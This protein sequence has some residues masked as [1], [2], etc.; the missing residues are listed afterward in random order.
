MLGA[1]T[2]AACG[3]CPAQLYL[4]FYNLFFTSL[5]PIV[6][7]IFDQ[8][9]PAGVLDAYP[10]LYQLGM[11]GRIYNARNFWMN[12]A[13]ACWESVMIFFVPLL[14]Y[15]TSNVGLWILGTIWNTLIILCVTASLALQTQYWTWINGAVVGLSLLA[16]LLFAIVYNSLLYQPNVYYV[17]EHLLGDSRFYLCLLLAVPL[18]LLPRFLWLVLKQ[19]LLLNP[20]DALRQLVLTGR[21]DRDGNAADAG[22]EPTDVRASAGSILRPSQPSSDEF[23]PPPLQRRAATQ[24]ADAGRGRRDAL[25]ASRV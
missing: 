12:I 2:D 15:A 18:A 8:D 9:L 23:G 19:D 4:M 5:P 16:Y 24:S 17:M 21:I 22:A 1:H 7:A 25:D 13:D 14:V 11:Q 20:V 3:R 6:W 10:N